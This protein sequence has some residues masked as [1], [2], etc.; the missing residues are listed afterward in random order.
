MFYTD[1][2]SAVVNK[3][4]LTNWFKPS[5]GVRQGCPL[6][7]YLFILTAE[8]LSNNIRLRI[9]TFSS[10]LGLQLNIEKTKA[11]WLG[12]WSANKTQ[13]MQTK[14]VREPTKILGIYLSYDEKGNEKF[15]FNLKRQKM[16]SKSDM[17]NSRRLT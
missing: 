7:P 15:N 12:R 14:W 3:R 11:I 1:I 9:R 17:W 13:P 5:R 2:K 8:I 4:Y 16:Q 10:I 6:S